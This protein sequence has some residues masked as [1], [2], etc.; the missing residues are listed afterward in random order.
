METLLVNREKVVKN[1]L[2]FFWSIAKY[3]VKTVKGSVI[4]QVP[5]KK[6]RKKLL[7]N[8]NIGRIL[9]DPWVLSRIL[10]VIILR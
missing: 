5:K 9:C 8:F 6:K 4:F 1:V 7:S 3:F 10:A 2:M